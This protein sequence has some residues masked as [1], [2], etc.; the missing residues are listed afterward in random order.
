MLFRLKDVSKIAFI[1]F[2]LD[3]SERREEVLAK[4][5]EAA[6]VCDQ[7]DP[8][9]GRHLAF[10]LSYITKMGGDPGT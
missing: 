6:R 2:W 4:L 8:R 10:L 5:L 9:T 3:S 1:F 7:S